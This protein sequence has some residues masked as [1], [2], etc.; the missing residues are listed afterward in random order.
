MTNKDYA[1]IFKALANDNRLDIFFKI[2]EKEKMDFPYKFCMI[3][4][5]TDCLCIGAPTVSHHLKELTNAG[6]IITEK[7]GKYLKARINEVV[8]DELRKRMG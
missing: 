4:E 6:L 5:I 7:D 2:L 1:K 8:W 3:H